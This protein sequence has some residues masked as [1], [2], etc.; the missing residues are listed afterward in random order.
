MTK[1]YTITA[2]DTTITYTVRTCTAVAVS[3][4]ETERVDA[5][6]VDYYAESGEHVEYVVFNATMPEDEDEF[7]AL[8][9]YSDEWD[10]YYGTIATVCFADGVNIDDRVNAAAE[11]IRKTRSLSKCDDAVVTICERAGMLSDL[12][13]TASEL[14]ETA[15]ERI[16]LL[17]A[18]NLLG[19]E[20]R[21][22]WGATHEIW[23]DNAGNVY[24]FVCSAGKAIR[25]F[26]GWEMQ[27]DGT[28]TD[29]LRQIAEDPAAYR[30]WD[31]DCVE[32][33]REDRL[34]NRPDITAQ[35]LYDEIAGDQESKMLYDGHE[36]VGLDSTTNYRLF[37]DPE[38]TKLAEA[39]RDAHDWESC[40]DECR[41]LCEMADMADEW[42]NADGDTSEGVLDRAADKLHVRIW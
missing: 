20:V 41:Q 5:L 42:G 37:A 12:E 30:N 9:D 32:R 17:K 27:P 11:R 26:A 7:I 23:E 25:C 13:E 15:E 24:W 8:F 29:A 3:I 19:V 40:N 4:G 2:N 36:V 6:Y 34:A 31:G 28:I 35:D 14:E 10:S 38:A 33:I 18:A 21:G 1:T 22:P 39:I 16:V